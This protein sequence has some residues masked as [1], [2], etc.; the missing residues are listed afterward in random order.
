MVRGSP[1]VLLFVL[2]QVTYFEK[3]PES[4]RILICQGAKVG[5]ICSLEEAM[6]GER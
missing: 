2:G 1:D 5:A 6:E 4:S 3:P